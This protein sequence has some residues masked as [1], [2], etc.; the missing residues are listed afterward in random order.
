MSIRTALL[1]PLFNRAAAFTMPADGWFH[2]VPRGEFYNAEAGLMQVVDD[3]SLAAMANRFA[4]SALVDFDHFSY[5]PEKSSEAAAWIDEVQVRGDGLWGKMRLTDVGEPALKNGR[6]RFISPVW[7]RSDVEDLGNNRVRPLRLD[8]AG[9]TN[10]PNMKGMVAL[11]NRNT[12]PGN[13]AN[14]PVSEP[15]TDNTNANMKLLATKLGLS[16]DAAENVVLDALDKLMNRATTAETTVTALTTERDTLRNRNSELLTEQIDGELAEHK[17]TDAAKIASVK[18]YLATLKNRAER[19]AFLGSIAPATT[20]TTTAPIT[21]RSTAKAPGVAGDDAKAAAEEKQAAAIRNRASALRAA[22]P[23][24]S[25]AQAY[26]S[27][28]AELESK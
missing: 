4:P 10:N 17:I 12:L 11:T 7:L 13:P 16:A 9:L 14:A 15:T 28:A 19:T 26:S 27:A 25:L 21:N 18:P 3:A 20:T 23:K 2:L 1:T 24:L 8:T 5:D 22:N 6:Y